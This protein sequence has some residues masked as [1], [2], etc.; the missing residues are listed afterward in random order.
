MN[1]NTENIIIENEPEE[2]KNSR[3]IMA[4]YGSREL[5]GQW[6]T[7][8]FGFSV[9]FFYEVVLGLGSYFTA[10]GFIVYSI[11]NAFNDPITGYVLEKIHMPWR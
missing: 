11:W 8:A 6:I 2:Y 1:I 10:A 7:G 3:W 9:F 5:F 4:S